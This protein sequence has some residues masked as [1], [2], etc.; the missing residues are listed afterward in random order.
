VE[1]ATVDTAAG[2]ETATSATDPTVARV[3]IDFGPVH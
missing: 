3:R 2:A 1:A